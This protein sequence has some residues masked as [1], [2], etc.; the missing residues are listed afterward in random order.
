MWG[1]RVVAVGVLL[2]DLSH[3]RPAPGPFGEHLVLLVGMTVAAAWLAWLAADRVDRHLS[4][5][6]LAAGMVGGAHRL[7]ALT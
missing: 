6:V 7:A 4:L 2:A 1:L 3:G 5:T